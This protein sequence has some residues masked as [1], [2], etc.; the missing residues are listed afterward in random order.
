MKFQPK[1]LQQR[2]LV[3]ILLPTFFFLAIL[4][5]GGFLFLRGMLLKQ[6]GEVSVVALER[7]ARFI[8]MELRKPKELLLLL[9]QG[10]EAGTVSFEIFD[11]MLGKIEEEE[12]VVKI[13]V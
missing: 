11:Y 13:N 12:L 5:T 8:D 2:T 6:W 9:P 3:Y 7:T 1:N 10:Y 4:S